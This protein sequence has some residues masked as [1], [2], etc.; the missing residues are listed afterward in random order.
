G[1]AVRRT[2]DLFAI[3]GITD[4]DFEAFYRHP[5]NAFQI[6]VVARKL[7]ALAR[8]LRQ[9]RSASF[10]GESGHTTDASPFTVA[11]A[12]MNMVAAFMKFAGK[13]SVGRDSVS[14]DAASSGVSVTSSASRFCSS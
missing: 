14:S 3:E 9:Y 7:D 6:D 10:F 8:R 4:R 2:R 13:F 1:G 5:A 12:C 11:P